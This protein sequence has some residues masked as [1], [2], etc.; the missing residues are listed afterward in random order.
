[1][2]TVKCIDANECRKSTI[3]LKEGLLYDVEDDADTSFYRI[4]S[5]DLY[6][7]QFLKSRFEEVKT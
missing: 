7:Q 4:V 2:I 3:S 5:G 6:G 1:M